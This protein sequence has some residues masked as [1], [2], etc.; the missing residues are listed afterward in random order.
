MRALVAALALGTVLLAGACGD[1]QPSATAG[2]LVQGRLGDLDGEAHGLL[3]PNGELTVVVVD[4]L[5]TIGARQA[6]DGQEHPAPARTR[7]VALDWRLEPGR[8]IDPFQRT[9]MEDQTV[10]TNLALVAGDVSVELGDAPGSTGTPTDTRTSGIVYV[11]VA[12]DADAVVEVTFDGVDTSLDLGTGEVSGSQAAPLA[13]LGAPV[14]DDCPPLRADGVSADVDCS[15]VVTQVPY[16]AGRGWS[17]DGWTV[18]QVETRVDSFTRGASSYAVES[19]TDASTF[20][21]VSGDASTVVDDSLDSLVARVAA[22]GDPQQL[23]IVRSLAGVRTEGE[24][25]DD[26]TIELTG[27]LDLR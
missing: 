22:E 12:Q 20:V 23:E 21:G 8:G 9:L 18:A 4:G 13:D 3:T 15:Y 2:D 27:S 17:D 25:P 6:A 5:D 11:A 19:V 16:L 7:W 1:D 14:A 10:R 24:G 26:A